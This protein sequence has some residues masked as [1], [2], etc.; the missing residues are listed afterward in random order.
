MMTHWIRMV[1]GLI[2]VAVVALAGC[3]GDQKEVDDLTAQL[4]KAK[5]E[6]KQ[7]Q[8]DR[9]KATTD[10]NAATTER[11]ALKAEVGTYKDKVESLNGELKTALAQVT[12]LSPLKDQIP[13][14]TQQRDQAQ[15][16]VAE[17]D[18]A[19]QTLTSKNATQA[20]TITDLTARIETLLAQIKDLEAKIKAAA[21]A[22]PSLG[23]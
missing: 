19:I 23:G 7:A 14:L 2:L 11:D 21:A 9:D 22:V 10:L 4:S 17:A 1:P 6:A 16:K 5:A 8:D 15:A 13:E 3:Q 12:S 20:N 18:G